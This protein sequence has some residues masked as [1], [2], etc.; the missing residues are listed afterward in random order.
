M[1]RAKAMA[2]SA[3]KRVGNSS[4]GSG[5][6]T[7]HGMIGFDFATGAYARL[8][9]SDNWTVRPIDWPGLN[10]PPPVGQVLVEFDPPITGDYTLIVTP[11]RSP[12]AP[13]LSCNYGN[14]SAGSFEVILF[15][16]VALL[17][18]QTVRN[19][20]FSFVVIQ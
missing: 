20:S 6:I 2:Q 18:Y 15:N 1:R 19:G 7:H 8:S 9:G 14:A 17:S 4:G 16:P 11:S 12:D 5:G 10:P 3:D 13:M